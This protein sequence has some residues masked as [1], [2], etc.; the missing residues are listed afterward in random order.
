M[1]GPSLASAQTTDDADEVVPVVADDRLVP[2]LV[3]QI[4]AG[5]DAEAEL[6]SV[7][8]GLSRL[9]PVE[10]VVQDG[11]ASPL[12]NLLLGLTPGSEQS[13][14]RA[15]S[16]F[17]D[18]QEAA[19]RITI[20]GRVADDDALQ[21]RI[22]RTLFTVTLVM[23]VVV[24]GLVA[25]LIRPAQGALIG[26][27]LLFTGLVAAAVGSGGGVAFDGSII[28]TSLVAVLTGLL[29][30]AYLSLRLLDWFSDPDGE[31][32]ADM[33]R[34]SIASLGTELL[35]AGASLVVAAAFLQIIGPGRSVAAPAFLGALVAV[36]LTL[37]TVAPGLAALEGAGMPA[38][39][40]AFD[41]RREAVRT[42]FGTRPNGRDF[43]IAVILAFGFAFGFLALVAIS[44]ETEPR[45]VDAAD[46]TDEAGVAFGDR[47]DAAGGD[48]T[49]AVLARFPAGTDQLAKAAWLQRV[50]EL[51]DV[52]RVDTSFTR[53][54][55]GETTDLEAAVL[56]PLSELV[57]GDEA[58]THALV[59][60]LVSGRSDAA[61]DLVDGIRAVEGPVEAELSGV[62]VEA[63]VAGERDRSVVWVTIITLTLVAGVAVFGLT[64]DWSLAAIV[65][66]LRLLDAM[67]LVGLYHLVVGAVSGPELLTIVMV[68]AVASSLF[69]FGVLRQLLRR[70]TS[71]EEDPL[72]SALDI[73]GWPAAVA[74]AAL[75]VAG[76]GLVG[77]GVGPT[78]RFGVLLALALLVELIVGFWLLRP[79]VLGA[80]AINAAAIR[81]VRDA[82]R[83]LTGVGVAHDDQ[84]RL[85]AAVSSLLLTEFQFQADPGVANMEDVFVPNTPL[86]RNAVDHHR[87]L[88]QAGLRITGRSPQLRDL[89]VVSIDSPSTVNV[90]V[91]H[92]I[93]QLIDHG[94]KVVGV[95]KPE[96]RTMMLWLDESR[97]G[98]RI[99][100]SVE[101]GAQ[102]LEAAPAPA[103]GQT[104]SLSVE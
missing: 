82:L 98:Y 76:L 60:P 65:A 72:S 96:R 56:S 50:S 95:R 33:I 30:A 41:E 4:A 44:S 3:V 17:I 57:D 21:S 92:P 13:G 75:A 61:V 85:H 99:A 83:A 34:R 86:F 48:P 49:V 15:V 16:A 39:P 62:P 80:R 43:P 101:L 8:D 24:G 45:L 12:P 102:V 31:D 23:A 79:A 20:G 90:T 66:A 53:T 47:L 68:V 103:V 81:T 28:T 40:P 64:G 94:G 1:F 37:A 84:A 77:T 32:L 91:D 9:A 52:G 59:V 26:A 36:L 104:L 38:V 70:G 87:N 74:L 58:P 2:D 6:R 63:G 97:W 67:A 73:E 42:V 29:V 89:Q 78:S 22:G 69:E 14:L 93:R 5:S 55:A 7:A 71:S 19:E 54:V 88:A 100:D 25:W 18:D 27:S 46:R 10:W 51:P 35:L 11:T